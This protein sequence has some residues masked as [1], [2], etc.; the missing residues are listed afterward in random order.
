MTTHRSLF[1]VNSLLRL[2][3]HRTAKLQ[4]RNT[5]SALVFGALAAQTSDVWESLPMKL[6]IF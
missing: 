6:V 1:W 5:I 2:D 4:F 3:D